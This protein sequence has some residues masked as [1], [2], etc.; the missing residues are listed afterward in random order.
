MDEIKIKLPKD[1]DEAL[2]LT[3]GDVVVFVDPTETSLYVVDSTDQEK[4][5]MMIASRCTEN[6]V[7]SMLVMERGCW[8]HFL[9]SA[10]IGSIRTDQY[11][12]GSAEYQTIDELLRQAGL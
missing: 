3:R 6:S 7:L 11:K 1:Y 9:P 5:T 10:K 8:G 4:R 2:K 12:K